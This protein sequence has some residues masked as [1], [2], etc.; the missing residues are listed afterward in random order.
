M[1]PYYVG[2]DV[3]SWST[4]AVVVDEKVHVIGKHLLRSGADFKRA[5][6]EAFEGAMKAAGIDKKDVH[7][8]VATGYGRKNVAIAD[9]NRTEIMCHG[10]GAHNH[11]PEAATIIDIGGQDNKVIRV[12]EHGRNV[13]FVLNRKCAAGTGAFL[14]EVA[15]RLDVKLD[16]LDGL[17]QRSTKKIKLGS[18]CTVFTGSE[19]LKLIQEGVKIE[20]IARGLYLSVAMRVS[21]MAPLEGKVVLTG[22]VIANNPILKDIFEE[23]YDVECLVPPDPQFIGAL[24][25]ALVALDLGTK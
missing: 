20:D 16:D 2:I 4:K 21:E 9:E 13:N 5:A 17:A 3:G 14:E 19:I 25:A 22:G 15:L 7:K 8:V 11:F 18:F 23:E 12:D 24:G 6:E 1:S 10:L